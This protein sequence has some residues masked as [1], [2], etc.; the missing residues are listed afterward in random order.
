MLVSCRSTLKTQSVVSARPADAERRI[1]RIDHSLT[2]TNIPDTRSG[3]LD[4]SLRSRQKKD[5]GARRNR[6]DDLMLAKHALSQLSYGPSVFGP[7]GKKCDA[8]ADDWNNHREALSTPLMHHQPSGC[9][10]RPLAGFPVTPAA[11]KP[12]G[13]TNQTMPRALC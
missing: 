8:L 13:R 9:A 1:L 5:G 6:T 11:A 3:N 7:K 4:Y 12:R 10:G 2:M